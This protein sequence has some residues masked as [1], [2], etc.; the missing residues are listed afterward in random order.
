MYF[1]NL[2]LRV[3]PCP[4]YFELPDPSA[5]LQHCLLCVISG[6]LCVVSFFLLKNDFKLNWKYCLK[7]A[8]SLFKI[9]SLCCSENIGLIILILFTFFKFK[10]IFIFS[11]CRRSVPL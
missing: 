4:H 11:V 7:G 3:Y 6:S 8:K 10:S 5:D 9:K 2:F 1:K